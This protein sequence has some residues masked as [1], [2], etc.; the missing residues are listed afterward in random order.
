MTGKICIIDSPTLAKFVANAMHDSSVTL[1]T[2]AFL[3]ELTAQEL[4]DFQRSLYTV[5]G[6]EDRVAAITLKDM[7]QLVDDAKEIVIKYTT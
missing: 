4:F 3:S 7:Q 2:A 1:R 6:A 5:A